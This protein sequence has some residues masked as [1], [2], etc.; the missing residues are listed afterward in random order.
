MLL[1]H[2]LYSSPQEFAFVGQ[3]LR[4]RAV[5]HDAVVTP[6]YT[7]SNEAATPDWRRWREAALA[8]VQPHLAGGARVVLG[9]LCVGG[10][11][12]AALA[13]EAPRNVAGLV[14]MSPTFA[15]DGWGLPRRRHL[16]RLAYW[17]GL[18]RFFSV[19]EREPFGIKNPKIRKWVIRDLEARASS[20][21]GPARLPLRALREGERLM[22]E[23]RARL[24]ELRCPLLIMHAREDEITSLESVQRLFASLPQAD[25]ALAVLEDSYHMITLDNARHEVA[26][27]LARFVAR[28]AAAQAPVPPLATVLPFVGRAPARAGAGR[29]LR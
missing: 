22:A 23:V 15:Y 16:R 13:L 8:A 3:E 14:L 27:L 7:L 11:L 21:V 1:F 9:G 29:S 2:G 18:D 20:A 19:A 10:V 26:A 5:A 12:A 17:T 4:R 24:S 6:G 25:K 28:L